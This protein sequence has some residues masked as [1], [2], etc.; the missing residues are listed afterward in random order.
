MP[1]Y[2]DGFVLMVPKKNMPA[3]KKM[4]QEGG[5]IWKKFGALDYKEC[6]IDDE[7]PKNIVRTFRQLTGAKPSETI[8]FSFVTYR[9]KK[10]RDRINAKVMAFYEKKYTGKEETSM[11]FA[12]DRMSFAGFTAFVDMGS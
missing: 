10:D 7:K 9:S 5:K 12:M 11:P 6:L 3:Y 8:V 4:A 1:K 2:V